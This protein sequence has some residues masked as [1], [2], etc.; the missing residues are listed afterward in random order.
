MAA[1]AGYD[2]NFHV[3]AP[4]GRLP[5]VTYLVEALGFDVNGRDFRGYTP[6]H[7]AAFRGDNEMILYL[8][9]K[10]AEAEAASRA[11]WIMRRKCDRS[12][13]ISAAASNGAARSV[14]AAGRT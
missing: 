2:G 6:L 10:G 5:A 7:H 14:A 13:S 4:Y 9:S 11:G 1:G 12:S 8:V 3:N